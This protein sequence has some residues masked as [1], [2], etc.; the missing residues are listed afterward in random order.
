MAAWPQVLGGNI[1]AAHL[2]QDKHLITRDM[3]ACRPKRC[4]SAGQASLF[5]APCRQLL[6]ADANI[7]ASAYPVQS[8]SSIQHAQQGKIVPWIT[9]GQL[10]RP[11]P[12]VYSTATTVAS[13]SALAR[14]ASAPHNMA[15]AGS[16]LRPSC[17]L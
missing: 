9:L 7:T 8:S 14:L 2:D 1:M 6:I 5:K 12:Y 15:A 16:W 13:L 17:K 4:S 11:I 3:P 10:P